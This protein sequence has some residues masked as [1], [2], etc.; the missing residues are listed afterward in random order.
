M[1]RRFVLSSFHSILLSDQRNIDFKISK[2]NTKNYVIV[3]LVLHYLFMHFT[4]FVPVCIDSYSHLSQ[5]AVR[6]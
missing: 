6:W 5:N 2:T 3:T 1:S 4:Y